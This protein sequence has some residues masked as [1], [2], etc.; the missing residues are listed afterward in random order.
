MCFSLIGFGFDLT[1]I[2]SNVIRKLGI[3]LNLFS[4]IFLRAFHFQNRFQRTLIKR[5]IIK[6]KHIEWQCVNCVTEF[7]ACVFK[8]K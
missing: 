3:K 1:S 4:F 2:A 6:T 7:K 5:E 8:S